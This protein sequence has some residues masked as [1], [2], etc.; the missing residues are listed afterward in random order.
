LVAR[1][2]QRVKC[3]LSVLATFATAAKTMLRFRACK[4]FGGILQEKCA[5]NSSQ[6]GKRSCGIHVAERR[7]MKT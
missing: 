3:T 6:C 5:A 4:I 1:A 7:F 2:L